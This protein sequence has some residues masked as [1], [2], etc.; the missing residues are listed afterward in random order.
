MNKYHFFCFHLFLFRAFLKSEWCI[1]E[2]QTALAEFLMDTVHK[3]IVIKLT[4][5]PEDID[6]SIEACLQS[7]TYL[8]WGEED[9]WQKLLYSLPSGSV[10]ENS[11]PG[12]R[13]PNEALRFL[14]L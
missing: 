4:D 5:L 14:N 7:T 11:F 10:P 13:R 1:F 2:F 9:F 8:T 12:N 6:S 3:I